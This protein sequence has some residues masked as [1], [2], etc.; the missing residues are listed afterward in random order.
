[1]P[2]KTEPLLCVGSFHHA[3]MNIRQFDGQ[4]GRTEKMTP[5]DVEAERKGLSCETNLLVSFQLAP[6][7]SGIHQ[8]LKQLWVHWA[9]AR[10]K[11]CHYKTD[12][13]LFEM[14]LS[15]FINFLLKRKWK[16]I[17]LRT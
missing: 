6:E 13:E 15:H 17:A 10:A 2:K 5:G 3:A 7:S 16:L 1:M 8:W 9:S 11:M 12:V 14:P 4:D